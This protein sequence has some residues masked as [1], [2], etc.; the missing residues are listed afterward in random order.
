MPRYLTEEQDGKLYEVITTKTP[1]EVGFGLR[2]NWTA[3]MARKWVKDNFGVEY[4]TRGMQ[5][6]LH[7]LNLSHTRPT[8]TMAKADEAKQE[9]FKEEFELLK[10]LA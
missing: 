9:E 4:S 5:D 1:D 6:V 7:S 8:Y 10:K 2:K 3:D